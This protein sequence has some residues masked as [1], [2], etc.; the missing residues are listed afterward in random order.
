MNWG[1]ETKWEFGANNEMTTSC[2]NIELIKAYA[3]SIL[4]AVFVTLLRTLQ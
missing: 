4:K 3:S 2:E 1:I